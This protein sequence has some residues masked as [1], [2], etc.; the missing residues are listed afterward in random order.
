MLYW[1]FVNRAVSFDEIV[2]GEVS[3]TRNAVQAAVLVEFDIAAV[4][5]RLQQLLY[6]DAVTLLGCADEVVVT[7]VEFFPSISEKGCD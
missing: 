1:L 7:D 5:T 2:F 4:V 3:L 6:S